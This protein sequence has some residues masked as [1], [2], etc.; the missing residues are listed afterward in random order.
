MRAPTTPLGVVTTGATKVSTADAI[1]SGSVTRTTVSPRSSGPASIE[2]ATTES[3]RP[4]SDAAWAS[5]VLST[6]SRDT[7]HHSTAPMTTMGMVMLNVT[8]IKKP[9]IEKRVSP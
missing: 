6:A 2:G 4:A 9:A 8:R 1:A 7:N 5:S 3:T